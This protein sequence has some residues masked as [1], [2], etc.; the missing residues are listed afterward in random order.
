[1]LANLPDLGSARSRNSRAVELLVLAST[2]ALGC[3]QGTEPH[4]PAKMKASGV[5]QHAREREPRICEA[6]EKEHGLAARG[7]AFRDLELDSGAEPQARE[8]DA[9]RRL[10]LLRRR[11]TTVSGQRFGGART[12]GR[13]EW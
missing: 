12:R 3:G 6:V 1:M 8:P 11:L 10:G 2:F 5:L 9:G 7:T 13:V 4:P